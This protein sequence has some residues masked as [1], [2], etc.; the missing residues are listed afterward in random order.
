M[1]L[2][3]GEQARDKIQHN[4]NV[5]FRRFKN[6]TLLSREQV[7]ERAARYLE[8]IQKT[9][10]RYAQS[11]KGVAEASKT[12][13]LEITALNVRY[14]LMYSQFSKIGLKP[15]TKTDGCT[16]FAALPTAAKNKHMIMGQNW[17]WIPEVKGLFLKVRNQQSPDVLCFTEAGVVGGK[18]GL[19]SE[20]LGLLINGIVSSKDDWSR[21]K[22]P[23]HV[24][25]WEALSS[26]TLSR[27]TGVITDG[28]RSCSA[29]FVLGQQR[30]EEKGK[31]LDIESAPGATCQLEPSGGAIAHTNHFSNP[32]ALG[33]D[34]VLDD[35]RISTLHRYE[36]IQRLL[37][38]KVR[39]SQNLDTRLAQSMLRD[40]DGNPESICR[41]ANP[42][43]PEDERYETV[44]SVVMDLY[45]RTLWA[46]M[47]HPCEQEYQALKL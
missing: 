6:E 19:N 24:R 35:E 42:R 21:L 33:V 38:K 8:V 28:E 5:Y 2:Q 34:Q 44:V 22:K 18:V 41:H 25:C 46:T 7:L 40:H 1:G 31:V 39:G 27:A 36:R 13:Q 20:G 32:S 26:R 45:T 12:T 16:A 37:D 14:E 43:F 29:N 4:L 9:S 17:D 3:H 23:F 30:S 15:V 47:G 11:M 10:P